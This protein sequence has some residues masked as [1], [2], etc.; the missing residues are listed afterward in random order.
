MYNAFVFSAVVQG[1]PLSPNE[2]RPEGRAM[3]NAECR[4]M[5]AECRMQ[6]A[7]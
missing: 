6:S 2:I 4:M 1:L 7:E 5:N 3:L